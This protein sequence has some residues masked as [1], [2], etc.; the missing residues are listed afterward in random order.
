MQRKKSIKSS[1]AKSLNQKEAFREYPVNLSEQKYRDRLP[2]YSEPI[3]KL[4]IWTILKENV[5][6]DLSRIALPVV[7]NEPITLL[8]KCAE[9]VEY[10]EILRLANR[11]ENRF[12]RLSYVIG[13][14][15]IL[16]SNT[17]NRIS[18]PFNPIMGETY[19]YFENDLRLVVEQVSHHPPIS[20]FYA[21]SNDFILEGNIIRI[22]IS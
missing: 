17:I 10:Q 3:S 20:A 6:K 7:F 1:V 19:E 22:L 14:V 9:Y 2:V 16:Y 12:L 8:Q 11:T 4:N 15:Y 21:E 13:S 5:G 18:K